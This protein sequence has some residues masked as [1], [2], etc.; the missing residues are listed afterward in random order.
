[1]EICVDLWTMENVAIHLRQGYCGQDVK[2]LPVPIFN[3]DWESVGGV[4]FRCRC[5]ADIYSSI[6]PLP[7]SSTSISDL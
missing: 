6:L 2:V 3:V 1:M 7:L 5:R 4:V